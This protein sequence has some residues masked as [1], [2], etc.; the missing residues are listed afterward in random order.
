MS[1]AFSQ[2]DI[3]KL[4][5]LIAEGAQVH[6]E[7]ETLNEGLKDTVKHIAEEMGIKPSILNKAIKVAYKADFHKHREDFDALEN[8]LESVGKADQ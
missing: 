7:I 6:T 8:I 2:T 5:R 3:D 4:K 1:I